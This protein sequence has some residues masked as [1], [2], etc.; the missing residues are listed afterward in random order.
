MPMI[1]AANAAM[2]S[3]IKDVLPGGGKFPRREIVGMVVGI[4]M[5]VGVG[6]KKAVGVGVKVT[7]GVIVAEGV[8]VCVTCEPSA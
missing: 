2:P 1:V 6:V 5:T 4:G 8:A 3:T 7:I